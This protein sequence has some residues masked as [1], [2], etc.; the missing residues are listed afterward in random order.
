LGE[1]LKDKEVNQIFVELD[2]SFNGYINFETFL[3]AMVR[4]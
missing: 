1:S 2:L 3:E 4:E